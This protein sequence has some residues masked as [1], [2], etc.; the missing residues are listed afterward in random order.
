[1]VAVP[2][3]EVIERNFVFLPLCQLDQRLLQL[4]AC[5]ERLL[6]C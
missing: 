5:F 2:I 6:R 1:L 4:V 3:T